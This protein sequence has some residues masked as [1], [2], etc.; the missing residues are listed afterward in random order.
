MATEKIENSTNIRKRLQ[1]LKPNDLIAFRLLS[2]HF[3]SI[4]VLLLCLYL[5]PENLPLLTTAISIALGYAFARGLELGHALMHGQFFT[6]RFWRLNRIIGC[7]VTMPFLLPWTQWR[8]T[9][10]HHH[11][12][13]RIEG[14]DYPDVRSVRDIPSLISH[15]LMFSHWSAVLRRTLF[16]FVAPAVIK[17]EI[18]GILFDT[19]D[20]PDQIHQKILNEY[21]LNF[22]LW[23]GI[24]L[25]FYWT[26]PSALLVLAVTWLSATITHVL[27]EFP[28]HVLADLDD[29]NPEYNSYEITGSPVADLLTMNNTRHATHHR[30]P[31]IPVYFLPSASEKLKHSNS[32]AGYFSFWR[33]FSR[34]KLS[35]WRLDH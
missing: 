1:R 2:I 28:E 4:S 13:P 23:G 25:L 24:L 12:D 21:R 8:W 7:I 17:K 3:L 30:Y 5:L 18:N 10:F 27:I 14:F 22:F 29:S 19:V 31:E 35:D 34:E 16:S 20:L 11:K 32:S 26:A 6:K 15:H 9:H 33:R